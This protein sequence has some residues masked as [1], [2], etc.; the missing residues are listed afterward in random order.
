V[1]C[2]VFDFSCER[3][4]FYPSCHQKRAVEFGEWLCQQVIKLVPHWR[5][6]FSILKILRRYSLYNRKL[7]SYLNRYAWQSLKVY[8]NV[9]V[10]GNEG[11]LFF[12][13]IQL[14]GSDVIAPA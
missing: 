8:L 12:P 4:N 11:M 6:F 9:A 1:Q 14:A 13:G 3:W 7:L 5:M 10:P 2:G